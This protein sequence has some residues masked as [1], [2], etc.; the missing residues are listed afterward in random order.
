MP[1]GNTVLADLIDPQVM[2][3]M[4]IEKIEKRLVMT[5]YVK[6]DTTLQGQAGSTVT[7]PRT[8]YIGDAVTVEE[9]DEIPIRRIETGDASYAIQM[10]GIGVNISDK[11]ALSGL[12]DPIGQA[13]SQIS[14]SIASKV[15]NDEVAA[16][17]EA[18]TTYAGAGIINYT[19][20]ID[21][22]DLFEEEVA[23]DKILLVHPKQVTQLRKDPDFISSEK[24]DNNVMMTG[25]I[26]MVGGARI[27]P[28]KKVPLVGDKYTC[29]IVQLTFDDETEDETPAVTVFLKRDVNVE[30]ER[31]P[32]RRQTE[33]T[34]D[35]FF[36]A[37]LTDDTKV[38]LLKV[39]ADAATGGSEG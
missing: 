9:G 27:V 12:G 30:T 7:V 4:I 38:V 19:N 10:A 17:L 11:G 31:I 21:A 2:A 29:P 32:R 15:D 33:V 28:S 25:E 5:P 34:A 8:K 13:T 18:T 3:D 16:L 39:D 37:A 23:Q 20:I 36:V 24:Y 14:K 1:N 26:G 35:E 22:I 6:V